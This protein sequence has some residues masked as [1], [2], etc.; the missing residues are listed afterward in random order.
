MVGRIGAGSDEHDAPSTI[1]ALSGDVHHAYLAE[2]DYPAGRRGAVPGLPGDRL[3]VPQPARPQGAARHPDRR[4][5]GPRRA[6]HAAWPVRPASRSPGIEW[7]LRQPP[8]FDNVVATLQLD[9]RER[10]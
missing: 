8:I 6:H 3:A 5:A 9:G 1:V 4:L 2:V 10:D 7:K